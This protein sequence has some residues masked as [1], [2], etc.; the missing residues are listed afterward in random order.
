MLNTKKQLAKK[1]KSWES[2][3]FTLGV[4]ARYTKWRVA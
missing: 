3:M 1:S 4:R 2:E